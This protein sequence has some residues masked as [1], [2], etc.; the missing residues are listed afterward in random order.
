MKSASSN[1]KKPFLR[2]HFHQAA[3]FIALGSSAMLVAQSHST[4][5][6]IANL[7]YGISLTGLFTVSA[8]YHRIQ[9]NQKLRAWMRRL[10]HSSIFLLI[11]GTATPLFALGVPNETGNMLLMIFWVVAFVGIGQSLL[12]VNAPKWLAAILYV[13]AGWLTAPY[14]GEMDHFLG[15][16]RVILLV[17][18]GIIYTAGALVYAFKRPNPFPE[19]F[20]YHEIFHTMVIIAAVLHF[21]I[22]VGLTGVS[23]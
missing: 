3:A 14:L 10:D 15:R 2:G 17:L 23:S 8:L 7:I 12:W 16:T 21:V 6:V 19:I 20:G 4:R 11:A 5:A 22:I 1:I 18:G 9:W 13:T